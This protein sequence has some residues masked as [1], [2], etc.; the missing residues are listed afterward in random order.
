MIRVTHS[1]LAAMKGR[2]FQDRLHAVLAEAFPDA[3]P[4]DTPEFRRDVERAVERGR[5]H[6]IR[7]ERDLARYVC[8]SYAF[9]VDFDTRF[10][11]AR[12]ILADRT[13]PAPERLTLLEFWADEMLAAITGGTPS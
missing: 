7:R 10:P 9:G 12:D 3:P 6:A 8:L 11:A 1:Q 5:T 13:R 2:L 4:E